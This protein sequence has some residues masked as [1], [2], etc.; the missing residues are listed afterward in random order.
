VSHRRVAVKPVGV[1]Q[2]QLGV[3]QRQ[4]AAFVPEVQRVAAGVPTAV[5]P[6]WRSWAACPRGGNRSAK[7]ASLQGAQ[8]IAQLQAAIAAWKSRLLYLAR[9]GR[10]RRAGLG[11]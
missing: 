3:R 4:V 2:V 1:V 7:R 6:A 8:G 5:A 9:L 10:N 11:V